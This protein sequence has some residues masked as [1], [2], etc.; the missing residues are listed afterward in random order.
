MK[1]Q[2]GSAVLDVKRGRRS[3]ADKLLFSS[4]KRIPVTI[5]GFI[6]QAGNDDGE[7]TEFVVDVTSAKAVL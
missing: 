6:V 2:S 5:E 1:L 4:E 3:L 7:S